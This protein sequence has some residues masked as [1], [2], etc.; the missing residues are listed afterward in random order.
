MMYWQFCITKSDTAPSYKTFNVIHWRRRIPEM[1][2]KKVNLANDK[3][4]H[5]N[6]LDIFS[7]FK[8]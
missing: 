3:T 5:F 7:N 2:L 4:N 8:L 1:E 6:N